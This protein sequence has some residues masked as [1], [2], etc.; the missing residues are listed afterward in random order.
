[1][2]KHHTQVIPRKVNQAVDEAT[3]AL[4]DI[5]AKAGID[6]T[7]KNTK[8]N[9]AAFMA[10]LKAEGI[11]FERTLAADRPD[12]SG[13]RVLKNGIVIGFIPALGVVAEDGK[14]VII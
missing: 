4:L 2:S 10:A 12:Q 8:G 13:T 9:R 7:A 11:E 1:M 6:I 5:L 3:R 14:K